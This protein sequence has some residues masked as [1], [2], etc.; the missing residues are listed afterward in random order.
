MHQRPTADTENRP[1]ERETV[2]PMSG[3]AL[4]EA[5]PLVA[6]GFPAIIDDLCTTI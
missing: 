5:R 2:R 4:K 3:A 6:P 1:K